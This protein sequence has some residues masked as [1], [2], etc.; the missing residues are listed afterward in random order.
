MAFEEPEFHPSNRH[1]ESEEE[2]CWV[3]EMTTDDSTQ[4]LG[5]RM[6]EEMEEHPA[7]MTNPGKEVKEKEQSIID[8]G[9]SSSRKQSQ[10]FESNVL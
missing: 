10:D 6:M 8:V 3:P 4:F 1:Q 9:D 7:C 5:Q 2:V